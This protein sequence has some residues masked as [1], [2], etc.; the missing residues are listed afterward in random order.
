MI[1]LIEK[2]V[3]AQEELQ[4]IF[5]LAH[6]KELL[7]PEQISELHRLKATYFFQQAKFDKYEDIY[8]AAIQSMEAHQSHYKSWIFWLLFCVQSQRHCKNQTFKWIENG[9]KSLPYAL[10]Y[11]TSWFKLAFIDIL[12]HFQKIDLTDSRE[13][14]AENIVEEIPTWAWVVWTPNLLTYLVKYSSYLKPDSLVIIYNCSKNIV[15]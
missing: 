12:K 10:R 6:G 4:K 7:S 3:D 15:S 11:K 2:K 13:K 8:N 9:I 1:Y 5:D 14:I